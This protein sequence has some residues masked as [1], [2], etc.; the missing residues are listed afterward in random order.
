MESYSG[1]SSRHAKCI[2]DAHM[3][4]L[5]V[6]LSVVLYEEFCNA[7]MSQAWSTVDATLVVGYT[8]LLFRSA[9]R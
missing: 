7:G 6:G 5:V 3:Q 9:Q 8:T 2:Y 4:D 1:V